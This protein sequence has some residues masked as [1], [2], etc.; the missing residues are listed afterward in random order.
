MRLAR[1]EID[2]PAR[3]R[4]RAAGLLGVCLLAALLVSCNK[5][6]LQHSPS[7]SASAA[8]G[9]LTPALA[10]KVLAKVGNHDITLG[11]YAATLERMDA[12][13]R[14][15][16]QSPKRRKQLLQ[17][18]IDVDLLAA[19]ARRRGLDKQPKTKQRIRQILRD[20]L[21]RELRAKEPKP[22]ALSESTVRDYYNKH[23]SEFLEPERRR[24]AHIAL[25]D[26]AQAKKVL[27]LAEKA[28]PMQWGRLVQ[29][30]S[31]DKPPKP[32]PS[33]PLE[34]SGDL[35]IVSA[36]GT[37]HD[38]NP[39]VPNALRDAVF[40][41]DKLGGVYPHLVQVG[42]VFHIV[43]LVGKTAARQR[44]ANEAER[45]IRVRIV[46]EGLKKK[47]AAFDKELRARFPV[48]LDQAAL[49]KV[50]VPPLG[51]PAAA[52]AAAHSP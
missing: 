38:N 16:Y 32:S 52:S 6:A 23:K 43:R 13:E 37:A 39:S 25:K 35:G 9:G 10:A 5:K 8:P 21:M 14:L 41:I 40:K 27:A 3:W 20:E 2:A 24:V 42:S 33:H 15:R 29:Q 31:I 49:S 11:E 30:Y 34:L 44:S 17:E 50:A 48:K 51:P 26:Q 36:P 22:S 18:M 46:Q 1:C 19:E 4:V 7:A 28:T 45:A 12:F 47:E